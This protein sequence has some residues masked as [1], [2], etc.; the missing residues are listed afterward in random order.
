MT[1]FLTAWYIGRQV[2]L[3]YL[4]PTRS[5]KGVQPLEFNWKMGTPV[6]ILALSSLWIFHAWNPFSTNGWISNWVGFADSPHAFGF[7]P[8]LSAALAIV[9]VVHCYGQY[10][11]RRSYVRHYA[12]FTHPSSFVGRFSYYG[13]YLDALYEKVL[14]PSYFLISKATYWWDKR[15]DG[16]VNLAGVMTVVFAKIVHAIDKFL[17]DGLIWLTY[18]LLKG[19]GI[20]LSKWQSPQVQQQIFWL[21]AAL[22][23]ILLMILFL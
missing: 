5:G 8:Y 9:A 10:G 7:I 11:P 15:I 21:I 12:D 14:Q 4:T 19:L 20:I 1:V 16:A 17:I 22:I 3:T 2:W 23:A 18:S 6:L 13:W